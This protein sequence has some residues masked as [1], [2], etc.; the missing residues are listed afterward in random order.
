[1]KTK[2]KINKRKQEI[3]QPWW[4]LGLLTPWYKNLPH[5]TCMKCD[6][7]THHKVSTNPPTYANKNIIPRQ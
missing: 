5:K 4:N 1:M 2:K 3:G 6:H 7:P